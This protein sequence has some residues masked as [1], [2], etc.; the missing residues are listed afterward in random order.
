MA[1]RILETLEEIKRY[2]MVGKSVLNIDE[3]STFTGFSKSQIYKL[4]A[5]KKI[6]H[7][8]PYEGARVL[9]F[10]RRDIIKWMTSHSVKTTDEIA[11]EATILSTKKKK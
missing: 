9:Y 1:N 10:K 7:C 11:A 6:P 8:K 4:T 2:L 3:L 5:S